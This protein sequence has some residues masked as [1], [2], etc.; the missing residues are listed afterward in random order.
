MCYN[1]LDE[2]LMCSIEEYLSKSYTSKK[3]ADFTILLFV[4]EVHT[5]EN[6]RRR[7]LNDILPHFT[8]QDF[9]DEL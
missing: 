1:L 9:G 5:A 7:A 8:T 6:T 3:S 2:S 4:L